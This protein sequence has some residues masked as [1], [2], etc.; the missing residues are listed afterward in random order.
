LAITLEQAEAQL[1]ASLDSRLRT[2]QMEAYS[3]EQQEVK[4]TNLRTID[5][6]IKLWERK[7]E[8]LSG[9]KSVSIKQVT[10]RDF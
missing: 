7:I 1:E 9:R 8:K 10:P 3:I 6:S 5:E 2:L 4:R